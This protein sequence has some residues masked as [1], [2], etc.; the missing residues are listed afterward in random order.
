MC[1]FAKCSLGRFYVLYWAAGDNGRGEEVAQVILLR[2]SSLPG[3]LGSAMQLVG[4]DQVPIS[5]KELSS[6]P[7]GAKWNNPIRRNLSGILNCSQGKVQNP[8]LFKPS[9]DLVPPCVCLSGSEA[10]PKARPALLSLGTVILFFSAC[11]GAQPRCG[12]PPSQLSHLISVSPQFP[13][14]RSRA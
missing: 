3:W 11:L 14:K 13:A 8:T 1:F 5:C 12:G 2:G 10:A 7:V 9:Y 4:H 6:N